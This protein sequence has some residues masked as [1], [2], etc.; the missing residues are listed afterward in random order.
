MCKSRRLHCGDSGIRLSQK[1]AKSKSSVRTLRTCTRTFWIADVRRR[2]FLRFLRT[3]PTM[4]QTTTTMVASH[5]SFDRTMNTHTHVAVWTRLPGVVNTFCY[6]GTE[7]LTDS[8]GHLNISSTR[9]L[10]VWWSRF[11]TLF[12]C[13][14]S[15]VW[16]CIRHLALAN[17]RCFIPSSKS[18]T[19]QYAYRC[20]SLNR[21][22]RSP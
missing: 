10:G 2:F 5:S 1:L 8:T 20:I 3:R 7:S 15:T 21:T 11:S 12:R 18:I 17:A 14:K 16:H 19:W 22:G 13:N 6:N 4:L 9:C